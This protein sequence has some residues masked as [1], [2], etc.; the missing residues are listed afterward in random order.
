MAVCA[1]CD[2]QGPPSVLRGTRNACANEQS[3]YSG[4][5]T[6]KTIQIMST[7]DVSLVNSG[8]VNKCLSA[9]PITS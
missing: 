5:R 4:Q 3:F 2:L 7:R 1:L 6:C 8:L 9:V